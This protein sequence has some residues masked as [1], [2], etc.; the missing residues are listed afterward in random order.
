MCW[1][2]LPFAAGRSG[3]TVIQRLKQLESSGLIERIVQLEAM[4]QQLQAELGIADPVVE[5]MGPVLDLDNLDQPYGVEVDGLGSAYDELP[6]PDLETAINAESVKRG[7]IDPEQLA[8]DLA[9]K[10]WSAE[11]LEHD[12]KTRVIDLGFEIMCDTGLYIHPDFGALLDEVQD[13]RNLSMDA[14][15]AYREYATAELQKRRDAGRKHTAQYVR[16]PQAEIDREKAEKL[17]RDLAKGRRVVMPP[18]DWAAIEK[19][20]AVARIA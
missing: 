12:I 10:Y 14:L 20:P 8:V 1:D 5:E 7:Y 6:Y 16:R 15:P 13:L 9:D 19:E 17:Q 18:T 3:V 2:D 11:D 4:V